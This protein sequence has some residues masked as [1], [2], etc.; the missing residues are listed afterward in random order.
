MASNGPVRPLVENDGHLRSVISGLNELV[1]FKVEL[2]NLDLVY[3]I[4]PYMTLWD[5]IGQIWSNVAYNGPIFVIMSRY[6]R[7]GSYLFLSYLFWE[8]LAL[9]VMFV[10]IAMKVTGKRESG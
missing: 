8:I 5:K 6:D 9:S 7:L 4:M 1:H 10:S 3:Q 2:I